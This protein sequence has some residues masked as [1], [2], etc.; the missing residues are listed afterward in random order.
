[1]P[2]G[3]NDPSISQSWNDGIAKIRASWADYRREWRRLRATRKLQQIQD[4]LW[5][6]HPSIHVHIEMLN[7]SMSRHLK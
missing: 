1:M 3:R 6:E 4:L 7:D 2:A 5:D